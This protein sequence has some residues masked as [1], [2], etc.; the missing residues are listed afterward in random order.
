MHDDKDILSLVSS[1]VS[2]LMKTCFVLEFET[3]AIQMSSREWGMTP[4]KW[5]STMG[6]D[7]KIFFRCFQFKLE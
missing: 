7:L 3:T 2:E 4:D 5:K 6:F 1:R